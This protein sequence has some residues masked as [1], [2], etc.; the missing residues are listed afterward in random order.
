MQYGCINTALETGRGY[1]RNTMAMVAE[2]SSMDSKW[3]I[4]YNL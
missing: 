1:G 2:V 4:G 3:A